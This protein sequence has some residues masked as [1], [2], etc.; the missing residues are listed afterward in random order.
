MAGS[1]AQ[2]VPKVKGRMVGELEENQRGIVV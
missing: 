1:V 2:Q